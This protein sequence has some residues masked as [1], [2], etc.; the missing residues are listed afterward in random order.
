MIPTRFGVVMLVESQIDAVSVTGS[1]DAPGVVPRAIFEVGVVCSSQDSGKTRLLGE[2]TSTIC[3]GMSI[4]SRMRLE[5]GRLT[6]PFGGEL[7]VYMRS[8]RT[9]LNG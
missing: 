8:Q 3:I 1:G 2:L 7:T 6:G 9:S 4:Q 5:A